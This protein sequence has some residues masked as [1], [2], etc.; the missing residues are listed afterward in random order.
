MSCIHVSTMPP[1]AVLMQVCDSYH[2]RE[3]ECHDVDGPQ[4]AEAGQDGQEQVVPGL[5]TIQRGLCDGTG[6]ASQ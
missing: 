6:L 3:G 5:G 4:G 2:N 1:L